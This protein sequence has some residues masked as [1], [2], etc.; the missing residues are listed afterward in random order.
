MRD[1]NK[2][3]HY[4]P[5]KR[6][7]TKVF[8]LNLSH[9]PL[10]CSCSCLEFYQWMRTVH[11]YVNFTDFHSYQCTFDDE[12]L[13]NLSDLNLIV[14]ILRF[15]CVPRDW[16]PMRKATFTIFIVFTLILTATTSFRFRHTL[17]YHWLKHKVHREYLERHV[18]NQKY[19][20]DAF[21]SC[22]R[23]GAIWAKRN[24]LPNLENESTG[25]KFCVAQRDFLVGATIIDN[26]VR[27][28]NQSRKV[29]CII[30]QNFLKRGWCKEELLI[31]HQESL[32]RGKNI[33]I[34]IFMPDI[35]HN[36]LPDR[37]RYILNHVTCIKWPRDPAAQ[38]V[39]WIM[40]QRGLFDGDAPSVH[41]STRAPGGGEEL[42]IGC[43]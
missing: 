21:V 28:I 11:K 10:R 32:D 18:L 5:G 33:F 20:F 16:S 39:F 19:R 7:I 14:D 24:F 38:Q 9:N 35:V 4:N 13:V 31:A 34:C 6:N 12:K 26:I 43:T 17:R 3:I 40:L 29:V 2:I 23:V 22:D 15:H 1:I 25:M 42:S 27:S 36:Q 41:N 37:F 30:S 8:E